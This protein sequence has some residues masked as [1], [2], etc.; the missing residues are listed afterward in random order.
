MKTEKTINEAEGNAVL[1][2]VS[3]QRE[4]LVAFCKY[5]EKEGGNGFVSPEFL[6]DDF[7]S[8]Q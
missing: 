1:P 6:A 7:L 8:N 4:L 5:L 3:Q 2:L